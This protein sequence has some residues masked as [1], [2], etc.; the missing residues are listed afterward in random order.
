MALA[1]VLGLMAQARAQTII[2]RETGIDRTGSKRKSNEFPFWVN[3]EDCIEEN[4][5]VLDVGF[6]D[7]TP[8]QTF[9]VWANVSSCV[10]RSTRTGT[11]PQCW[12]VHQS[13]PTSARGTIVVSAR[14]LVAQRRPGTSNPSEPF[15]QTVCQSAGAPLGTPLV[16]TFMFVDGAENIQGEAALWDYDGRLQVG[17]DVI[18]PT[19][20][21]EVTAEGGHN[22]VALKWNTK[23]S[24]TADLVGFRFYCDATS[25]RIDAA[26]H[27]QLLD[28]AP[29]SG[30]AA[31][32]ETAGAVSEDLDAASASGDSGT[33]PSGGTRD[34][35]IENPLCPSDAIQAGL[36]PDEDFYCGGVTSN[37]ATGGSAKGLTNGVDYAV[38]VAARDQRGNVGRLSNVV[39]GTPVYVAG[40]F[41]LY[42]AAGG[43]AGGGLCAVRPAAPRGAGLWLGA[44]AISLL[45]RHRRRR[46]SRS[47]RAGHGRPV[48]YES[49]ANEGN[50]DRGRASAC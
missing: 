20:P 14:Q 29:P 32:F 41:E 11:N 18:A 22:R 9:E 19:P 47:L 37:S 15:D 31:S 38:G 48:R 26:T 7:F 6:M 36:R 43:Q 46:D 40:F 16:L 50:S 13:G 45:A 24:Q 27:L 1:F 34:G 25:A 4:D 21:T 33:T 39:C 28:A 44:I 42:R 49:P 3:Y 23:T 30:A 8:G 17:F 10:D 2:L 5:L 35:G 12:R